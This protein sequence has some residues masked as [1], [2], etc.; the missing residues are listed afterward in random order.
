MHRKRP[1][2]CTRPE[3][4]PVES[5]VGGRRHGDTVD[6]EPDETAATGLY[7]G[8]ASAQTQGSAPAK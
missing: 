8:K 1:V 7:D 5:R 2:D 3:L 4:A 6:A